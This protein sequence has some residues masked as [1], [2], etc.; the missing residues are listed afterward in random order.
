M[1]EHAKITEQVRDLF[2]KIVESTYDATGLQLLA[3]ALR[4]ARLD[5]A[6]WWSAKWNGENGLCPVDN[7]CSECEEPRQRIAALERGEA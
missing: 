2:C 4:D 7:K 3:D 1:S 6:R 5:E